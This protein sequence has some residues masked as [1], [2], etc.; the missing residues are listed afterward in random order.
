KAPVEKAA[1]LASAKGAKRAILLPVSAPFH[2]SLMRPAAD[3]MEEALDGVK[4]SIPVVPVI[5]NV[6]VAPVEDPDEIAKLLVAQVTGR[7]R[8]RETVSWFAAAEIETL[9]EVGAGKVLS[10]LARR[11]DRSVNAV[12][13]GAPEDIDGVL[14]AIKG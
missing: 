1:E 8:W 7:V 5:A 9:Y 3:A 2:S 11:I 12:S 13:V 14:K 10:G 6:S 4:K